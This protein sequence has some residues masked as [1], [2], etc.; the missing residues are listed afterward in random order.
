MFTLSL[1]TVYPLLHTGIE[2]KH[3]LVIHDDFAKVKITGI[4]NEHINPVFILF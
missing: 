2:E 1:H 4:T 3:H